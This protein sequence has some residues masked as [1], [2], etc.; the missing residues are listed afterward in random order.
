MLCSAPAPKTGSDS[1][2]MVLSV[3][4]VRLSCVVTVCCYCVYIEGLVSK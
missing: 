3:V 2:E 4:S 1:C